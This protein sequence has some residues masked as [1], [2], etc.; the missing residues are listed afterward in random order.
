MSRLN[1][2]QAENMQ[3]IGVHLTYTMMSEYI[4]PC[5]IVSNNKSIKIAHKNKFIPML[6]TEE[7]IMELV[8]KIIL[9]P[10]AE[11]AMAGA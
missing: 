6:T 11:L 10:A 9:F 8:V 7:K 1:S 2:S 3:T 4:L 5:Q